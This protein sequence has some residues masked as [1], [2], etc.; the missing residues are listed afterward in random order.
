M[1]ARAAV[2][3]WQI[4]VHG[5]E[6]SYPE[7]RLPVHGRY[8][9]VNAAVAVAAVEAL[10]GRRLDK[11]AVDEATSAFTAPGRMEIMGREPLILIDG[12]HNPAGFAALSGALEEE[13][14]TT[15]WV[16]VLGVMGDKDVEA[17]IDHLKGRVDSVIATAVEGDRPMPATE[18]VQRIMPR[19]QVVVEA[20]G[21]PTAALEVARQQAGSD[22]AVLVAG[23]IYLAGAIRAGLNG[24]V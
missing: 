11:G 17:M 18:L 7:L 15:R 22:G 14:P 16:L 8:Q 1:D 19:V 10:L 13:F 23:S 24:E 20:V 6:D 4:D 3:G 12:A 21:D 5:A 9:T 2:G